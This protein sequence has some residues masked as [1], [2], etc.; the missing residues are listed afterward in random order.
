MSLTLGSAKG[1]QW[2]HISNNYNKNI[3]QK[4]PTKYTFNVQLDSPFENSPSG[5][6][7]FTD[8]TYWIH[9]LDS[10]ILHTHA[11][12][13]SHLTR[14]QWCWPRT[15]ANLNSKIPR[16]QCPWGH[17]G[18]AYVG[19]PARL[20][21]V[22]KHTHRSSSCIVS[23]STVPGISSIIPS[24]DVTYLHVEVGYSELKY[25]QKIVCNQLNPR[26]LGEHQMLGASAYSP[27]WLIFALSFCKPHK[28]N[29]FRQPFL[30]FPIKNDS[31]TCIIHKLMNLFHREPSYTVETW[32]YLNKWIGQNE[33]KL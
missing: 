10:H 23:Y 8:F 20:I 5:C 13:T 2:K 3:I 24:Q 11:P 4:N 16:L 17:S 18:F 14:S 1:N 25:T 21:D 22:L 9:M 29:S 27:T 31:V 28:P 30:V 33:L 26:H 32:L 7:N 6:K 19:S 12:R 15:I